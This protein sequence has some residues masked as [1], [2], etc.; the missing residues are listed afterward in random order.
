MKA[1][2]I[3]RGGSNSL[4]TL[5]LGV[6][7]VG[8]LMSKRRAL[9]LCKLFPNDRFFYWEEIRGGHGVEFILNEAKFI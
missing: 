2:S 9:D 5:A 4:Q 6:K 3:Y 8:K 7:G 1:R